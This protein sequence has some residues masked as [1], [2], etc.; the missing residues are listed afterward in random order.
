MRRVLAF[1][2]GVLLALLGGFV[3]AVPAFAGETAGATES[4]EPTASP[5]PAVSAEP[6]ESEPTESEPTE[7]A[8]PKQTKA[9]EPTA[10]PSPSA[11]QSKPASSEP[12]PAKTT[13]APP[14]PTPSETVRRP[15]PHFDVVPHCLPDGSSKVVVKLWI[16]P[17]GTG[18]VTFVVTLNGEK[19]WEKTLSHE[20]EVETSKAF[21]FPADAGTQTF[22]ISADGKVIGSKDVKEVCPTPTP[23]P[24]PTTPEASIVGECIEGGGATVTV[25]MSVSPGDGEPV[26]FTVSVEGRPDEQVPVNVGTTEI[27]DYTLPEGEGTRAVTVTA[28]GQELD[29]ENV[30]VDC[31]TE[32][33]PKASFA[34]ACET[35]GGTK[36]EVHLEN[37]AT[38]TDGHPV[39]RAVFTVLVNGEAR[40]VDGAA[41][42]SLGAGEEKDLVLLLPEDSGTYHFEARVGGQTIDSRDVSTDCLYAN[43]Q[44]TPVVVCST[45]TVTFTNE[46]PEGQTGEEVTFN[47]I[48]DGGTPIPVVVPAGT[49]PAAPVTWTMTFPED[50][51]IHTVAVQDA[52]GA[53]AIEPLEIESDCTQ[54]DKT[55]NPAEGTPVQAPEQITYSVKITNSSTE[56]S[57]TGDVVDTLPVGVRAVANTISDGGTLSADGATI[58]WPDV[59]LPVG[60]EKT[61][62]FTVIVTAGFGTP[63]LDN[64]ATWLGNSDHT[65]HPVKAIDAH[66]ITL[67]DVD[68]PLY[69]VTV[70][71]QNLGPV[72][73]QGLPH[74]VTVEW[75]QADDTGRPIIRDGRG[76]PAFNP[77]TGEPYVDTYPLV[78]GSLDTGPLLWKGAKLDANGE[79]IDWPGWDL[80]D[81]VW[82]QVPDGGVRPASILKVT[83]NPTAFDT[84][85]YPPVTPTCNANPPQNTPPGETPPG[86]PELPKTGGG[87]IGP[88]LI[89]A[90]MTLISG[91]ALKGASL[92]ARR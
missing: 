16:G 92:L 87:D 88:Q 67:C 85:V 90:L 23:T 25:T 12:S 91:A 74:T 18:E 66:V 82:V 26:T 8:T 14:K 77:E 50:T 62:T 72:N 80:V 45:A 69:Q 71:S 39:L 64:E 28:N 32:A 40:T 56:A 59:S 36:V 63:T 13:S 2:L 61:F 43:P 30:P 73:E 24:T 47:V 79:P 46:V 31:I 41:S 65:I 89:L 51:G 49:T 10:E 81:G 86:N 44:V 27:R 52:E 15:S 21:N 29:K 70:Q 20:T 54:L 19:V 38:A 3:G 84:A 58:T 78:N 22:T 6:T 60:G 9:E 11:T 4:A 55:A 68:I 35:T 57:A 83:V 48:V 5:E 75:F 42:W 17:H 76:V 1:F 7:S 37:D 34:A 33:I 53:P